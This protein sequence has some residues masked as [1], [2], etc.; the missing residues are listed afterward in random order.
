MRADGPAQA[1]NRLAWTDLPTHPHPQ[2][3]LLSLTTTLSNTRADDVVLSTIATASYWGKSLWNSVSGS[4]PAQQPSI[5]PLLGDANT[6][7]SQDAKHTL[8]LRSEENRAALV[9]E[10]TGLDVGKGARLA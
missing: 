10:T 6:T 9:R 3:H 7:Y 1:I 5:K 8:S 4:T 2:S